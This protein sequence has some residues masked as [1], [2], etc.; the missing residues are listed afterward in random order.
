MHIKKSPEEKGNGRRI[1]CQQTQ[2]NTSV[3]N[4]Y[5]FKGSE[6]L[7]SKIRPGSFHKGI[8]L[9]APDFMARREEYYGWE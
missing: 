8:T 2:L 6:K 3:T 1:Y 7:L 9:P 4:P 5:A